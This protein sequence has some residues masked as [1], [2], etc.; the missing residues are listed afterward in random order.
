VKKFIILIFCLIWFTPL[1]VAA[2]MKEKMPKENAW[3]LQFA[4]VSNFSLKPFQGSTISLLKHSSVNR[5]WR[6]GFAGGI[7]YN[8]AD[9]TD[10]SEGLRR[11]RIDLTRYDLHFSIDL[12]KIFFANTESNINLFYGWGPTVSYHFNK[13]YDYNRGT[14]EGLKVNWEAGAKFV[15]GAQWF[16]TKSISLHAEYGS[17]LTY[18][19]SW[20]RIERWQ[21]D[22]FEPSNLYIDDSQT[23]G[24]NLSSSAVKLGLSA[25]F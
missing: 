17:K 13:G 25:Y 10:W 8:D 9:N 1:F 7:L 15:L 12:Q 3:A 2:G 5:A 11:S 21:F 16:L 18:I 19:F 14:M 4:V 22:P 23:E 20:K 6:I 24:L